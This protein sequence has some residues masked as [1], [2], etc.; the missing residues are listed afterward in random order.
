MMPRLKL[1]E[2]LLS[3]GR[4][5]AV[6]QKIG[7]TRAFGDY[8]RLCF[9]AQN[10]WKRDRKLIPKK[11]YEDQN[12]PEEF[13]FY[14]LVEE[15]NEG[16]YVKGSN[17][18]FSWLFERPNST[19][20][21]A[22]KVAKKQSDVTRNVDMSFLDDEIQA[23][24]SGVSDSMRRRWLRDYSK[25]TIT[26]K[27]EDCL[28]WCNTVGKVPKNVGLLMNKFFQD[29]PKDGKEYCP[30][31]DDIQNALDGLMQEG[32]KELGADYVKE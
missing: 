5:I 24:I 23:F 31:S 3:D 32:K 17:E 26:R 12:F 6:I 7:Q 10:F 13:V 9:L 29:V 22:D 20:E 21:L 1:E 4:F 19:V 27:L 2:S 15:K 14:N 18:H 11:I 16:Y 8:V 30:L 28:E 25:D